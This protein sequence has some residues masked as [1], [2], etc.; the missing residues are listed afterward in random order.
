MKHKFPKSKGPAKIQHSAS[1]AKTTVQSAVRPEDNIYR[2]KFHYRSRSQVGL[3]YS[4]S[5]FTREVTQVKV[6]SEA[7]R[8]SAAN[9]SKCLQ[10][11]V[12]LQPRS[13]A[14]PAK[15]NNQPA[16]VPSEAS[17]TSSNQQVAAAAKSNF[18][19]QLDNNN[20]PATLGIIKYRRR[21]RQRQPSPP[22][23]SYASTW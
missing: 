4:K 19:S 18:S 21:R 17:R 23:L 16:K 14:S 1:S 5:G 10:K 11:Q 9:K 13:R 2:G 12:E 6:P 7:S 20:Q 22:T 8:T 3:H 15:S